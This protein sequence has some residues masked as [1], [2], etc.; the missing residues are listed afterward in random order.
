[1]DPPPQDTIV[2]SMYQLWML[3]ALDNLG[4]LTNVGRKMSEFP[5]DPPLAKMLLT[6]ADLSCMQEMLVVLSMLQTPN[7]FY[8][9]KD[10]AEESDTQREKFNVPESDHLT[11][12]NVYQQWKKHNY[13][14]SWCTRHFIQPKSLKKV[15]ESYAQ[16]EDI[17]NQQKLVNT[18]CGGNWDAIR[19]AITS[20]YFHNAAKM[21]G[22]GEY[23]NLRSSV[24]CHLHPTSSLYGMGYTPD[25]VVYHE[26]VLT[27][28][29]Y[30]SHVTA[31]E[32]SWLAELGPMFFYVKETGTDLHA[33]K[34][35]DA[36]NQRK[37]EYEAQIE[38][39]RLAAKK[40]AE[41]EMIE[42]RRGGRQAVAAIGAGRNKVGG[43]TNKRGSGGGMPSLIAPGG[44]DEED[45]ET[46]KN[47]KGGK[48]SG[49]NQGKGKDSGRISKLE[50]SMLE[51]PVTG[52]GV[53]DNNNVKAVSKPAVDEDEDVFTSERRLNQ[54]NNRK[55]KRKMVVEEKVKSKD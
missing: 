26:V 5:L 53:P 51:F 42:S 25:Y 24:P 37:M 33:L 48:G 32:P 54:G 44:D 36:E 34:R 39:D 2:N 15:R 43:G 23:I 17:V 13:N 27:T 30:M 12:L 6:S 3:G 46:P 21:R 8:R 14:A 31:V 18:S 40:K 4:Y 22:V 16:L 38:A 55:K 35:Q 41:S 19:K 7:I 1:M 9:P 50:N 28:K 45:E 20:G 11:L 49:K 29:E 52:R 10:R 47:N